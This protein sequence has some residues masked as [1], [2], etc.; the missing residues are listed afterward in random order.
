MLYVYYEQRIYIQYLKNRMGSVQIYR[1]HWNIQASYIS[2][3]TVFT[4]VKLLWLG[5]SEMGN[6][7]FRLEIDDIGECFMYILLQLYS[8]TPEH[9]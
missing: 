6:K 9:N 8:V 5:D 3:H 1:L 2:L 4:T 7:Q